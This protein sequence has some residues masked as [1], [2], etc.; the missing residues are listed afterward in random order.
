MT[1]MAT[2]AP[3]TQDGVEELVCPY[4]VEA[5]SMPGH[6]G[7]ESWSEP[8]S[9][10]TVRNSRQ[11]PQDDDARESEPSRNNIVNGGRSTAAA[12]AA[13]ADD[14]D[15]DS[16]SDSNKKRDW[17]WNRLWSKCRNIL[18]RPP[19]E[20]SSAPATSA[21]AAADNGSWIGNSRRGISAASASPPPPPT[22]TR[23][24]T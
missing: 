14:N 17:P 10:R 2:M 6:Y 4:V 19:K 24:S 13:A 3:G 7:P 12:A 21:A 23:C 9:P 18:R 22:T 11:Q 1:N 16:D 8:P 20:N 15:N 5:A